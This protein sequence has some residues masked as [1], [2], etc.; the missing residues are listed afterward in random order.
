[1]GCAVGAVIGVLTDNA[2]LWIAVGI[3]VGAGIGAA[4]GASSTKEKNDSED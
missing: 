3:A 1:M 2:G 4:N